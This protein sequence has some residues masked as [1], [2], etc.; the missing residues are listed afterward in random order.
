MSTAT[1]YVVRPVVQFT[2]ADHDDQALALRAAVKRLNWRG[3]V[4]DWDWTHDHVPAVYVLV[5]RPDHD[6]YVTWLVCWP[7]EATAR[8]RVAFDDGSVVPCPYFEV[9]HYGIQ[10][11]EEAASDLSA[12]LGS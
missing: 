8:H 3:R 12:R 10:T 11:L 7:T 6:D 2:E 4:V 9:G 1:R 5:F